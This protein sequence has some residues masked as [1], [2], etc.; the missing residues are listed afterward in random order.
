MI[1]FSRWNTNITSNNPKMIDFWLEFNSSYQYFGLQAC[2]RGIFDMQLLCNYTV[3]THGT[4]TRK[5]NIINRHR[6]QKFVHFICSYVHLEYIY[7][8]LF[9]T[10]AYFYVHKQSLI[11]LTKIEIVIHVYVYIKQYLCYHKQFT[12]MQRH[13]RLMLY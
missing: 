12:A 10:L 9:E 1:V 11:E 8:T 13:M 5:A 6:K 7:R 3:I 4:K 2:S